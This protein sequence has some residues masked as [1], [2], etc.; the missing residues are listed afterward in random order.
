MAGKHRK[1]SPARELIPT[2]A[3]ATVTALTLVTTTGT[4]PAITAPVKT[5]AVTQPIRRPQPAVPHEPLMMLAPPMLAPASVEWYPSYTPPPQYYMRQ[6]PVVQRQQPRHASSVMTRTAAPAPAQAPAPRHAAPQHTQTPVPQ[7]APIKQEPVLTAAVKAVHAAV[8]QV[9]SRY[10][11]GGDS[12]GSFDCSGL[13]Q[14]AY[15]QSGINLPRTAAAQAGAGRPVSMSALRP[16]DLLFYRYGG[17]IE[18]VTMFV[19]NGQIAEAATFGVPVHVRPLYTE[20]LVE[21]RRLIN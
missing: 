16:G 20:G 13:V 3:G 19:G 14:W 4:M 9:G 1:P 12:P 2:A 17:G 21:A 18:H 8:S 10:V 15:R 11:W 6:R 5:E 7:Q